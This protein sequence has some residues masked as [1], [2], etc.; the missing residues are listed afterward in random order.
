MTM[1]NILGCAD[2]PCPVFRI[3]HIVKLLLQ[4]FVPVVLIIMGMIDFTKATMAH[5]ESG[6]S[7]AKE[8]FIKRLIAAGSMFFVVSLFQ[9]TFNIIANN[10]DNNVSNGQSVWECTNRMLNGDVSSCDNDPFKPGTQAPAASSTQ[11]T[12]N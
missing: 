1:F 7:K 11:N 2:I 9:L 10:G 12:G 3:T 4:I 6:I 8:A 5:D